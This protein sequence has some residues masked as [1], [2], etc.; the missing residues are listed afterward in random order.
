MISE[1]ETPKCFTYIPGFSREVWNKSNK[2]HSETKVDMMTECSYQQ[3]PAKTRKYLINGEDSTNTLQLQ[4]T[5][6]QVEL[7]LVSS[8]SLE[9][10]NSIKENVIN[11]ETTLE[12]HRKMHHNDD[13]GLSRKPLSI[14]HKSCSLPQCEPMKRHFGQKKSELN[15]LDCC[16]IFERKTRYSY[17]ISKN[18]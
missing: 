5:N 3:K 4:L 8:N 10:F 13:P 1:E 6:L 17:N 9:S 2:Y 12:N 18:P 15:E 7:Q 11:A 14:S 16:E